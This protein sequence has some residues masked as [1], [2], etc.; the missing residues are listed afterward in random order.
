M[1]S[2]SAYLQCYL[3]L[4]NLINLIIETKCIW[5]CLGPILKTESHQS[6]GMLGLSPS[7]GDAGA[8]LLHCGTGNREKNSGWAGDVEIILCLASPSIVLVSFLFQARVGKL[9]HSVTSQQTDWQAD[10]EERRDT[11]ARASSWWHTR[12]ELRAWDLWHFNKR[13]ETDVG[14]HAHQICEFHA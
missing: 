3:S 13:R 6:N 12:S 5:V 7:N 1:F 11:A 9:W 10:S 14:S 4:S 2:L 8:H